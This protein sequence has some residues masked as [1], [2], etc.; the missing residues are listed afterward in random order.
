[1][2]WLNKIVKKI[3]EEVH[4]SKIEELEKRI[5]EMEKDHKVMKKTIDDSEAKIKQLDDK[6]FQSTIVSAKMEATIQ[7]VLYLK[8]RQ[9]GQNILQLKNRDNDDSRTV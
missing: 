1:M 4:K 7:T 9:E 5:L 6:V 2:E 3:A 8:E